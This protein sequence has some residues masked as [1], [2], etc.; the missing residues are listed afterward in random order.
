MAG[1][2]TQL[3]LLVVAL[4][5]PS[6]LAFV[7]SALSIGSGSSRHAVRMTAAVAGEPL[8]HAMDGVKATRLEAVDEAAGIYQYEFEIEI[9]GDVTQNIYNGIEKELRKKAAF[10]GFRKGQIP[11][12]ARKQVITFSVEEAVNESLISALAAHGLEKLEG[13]EGNAELTQQVEDLVAAFKPGKTLSINAKVNA[14]DTAGAAATAA[15][16]VEAE[17]EVEEAGEDAASS[18]ADAGAAAAPAEAAEDF[19]SW[20]TVRRR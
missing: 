19:Y 7:P 2:M 13:K 16:E 17:A 1:T 11:P 14:K 9:Q 15:S 20:Q 8:A 6:S 4:L 3:A 18:D 10:P 12:F 5:A